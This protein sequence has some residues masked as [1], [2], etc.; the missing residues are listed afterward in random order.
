MNFRRKSTRS[1]NIKPI[2]L[3][4]PL[5]SIQPTRIL[6]WRPRARAE[7]APPAKTN[8]KRPIPSLKKSTTLPASTSLPIPQV[9]SIASPIAPTTPPKSK[10]SITSNT[11]IS[12]IKTQHPSIWRKFAF[13]RPMFSPKRLIRTSSLTKT[14]KIRDCI[15]KGRRL[16]LR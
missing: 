7:R 15:S 4:L 14:S 1:T 11:A 12:E 9:S 2:Q 13:M 10:S 3:R 5:R 6:P 8:T 16:R